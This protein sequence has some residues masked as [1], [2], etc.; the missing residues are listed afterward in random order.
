MKNNYAQ[1]L[2]WFEREEK[3]YLVKE[4]RTPSSHISGQFATSNPA[5]VQ[6]RVLTRN[7]ENSSQPIHSDPSLPE[8]GPLDNIENLSN[9][10]STPTQGTLF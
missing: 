7:N 2:A 9:L 4:I 1:Q 3:P 6:K 5:P 10:C 8:R